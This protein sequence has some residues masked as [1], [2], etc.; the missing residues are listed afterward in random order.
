MIRPAAPA[1]VDAVAAIVQAAYAHYIPRLGRK[2]APMEDD[3][4]AQIAAGCTWV[5]ELEAQLVGV[6]VLVPAHDHLLIE[7]VAV[8]PARRGQGLGT[9]LLRFAETECRRRRLPELRLYTNQKMV[10][11]IAMYARHGYTET[12]RAAEAGFERV[13]FSKPVTP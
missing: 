10:E 12:G 13:F 5:A 4:A 1:D 7:N 9:A 11:N 3:H 8:D 2:P 6:L